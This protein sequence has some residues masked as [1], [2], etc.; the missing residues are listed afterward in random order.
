MYFYAIVPDNV[1]NFL[2]S[3]KTFHYLV[4]LSG[5]KKRLLF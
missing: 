4:L 1:S 5:L 2:N 3:K